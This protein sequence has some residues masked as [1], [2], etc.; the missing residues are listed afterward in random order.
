MKRTKA[1]DAGKSWPRLRIYELP[2]PTE[3]DRVEELITRVEAEWPAS[4]TRREVLSYLHALL[5]KPKLLQTLRAQRGKPRSSIMPDLALDYRVRC[6]LLDKAAAACQAVAQAWGVKE[7]TVKDAVRKWKTGA[8]WRLNDLIGGRK[9][10]RAQLLE[11]VRDDLQDR[12]PRRGR[13]RR[14]AVR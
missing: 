5:R 10:P 12:R 2:R 8:E 1:A 3:R 11:W 13:A 9:E 6:E 14:K 4:P 7:A